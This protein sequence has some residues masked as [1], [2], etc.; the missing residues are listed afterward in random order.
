MVY[1]F[2]VDDA[3]LLRALATAGERGGML[4]VHCENRTILETLTARHLAAGE[5]APRYHASSRP[6]YVEAEATERAIALAR[7]ADAPLYVVHLSS[8]AALDGGAPRSRGRAAGVR[9]DV[10][11]LPD[12]RRV[13]LRRAAR[14]GGQGTSSRRRSVRR[15]TRT[16][17]GMAWPTAPCRWSPPTTCRTGSAVEKQSWR[18]SFDRI[19]NGGPGIET[20]L[21]MVY[22]GGVAARPDPGRAAWST[23][24]RRRRRGCS[25]CGRRGRSRSAATR[26]SCCST[27]RRR[28]TSP[29]RSDLHHTSDYT[30]Y[31]GREVRGGRALDASAAR[32]CPRRRFVGPRLRPLRC[33]SRCLATPGPVV[34]WTGRRPGP[35]FRGAGSRVEASRLDPTALEDPSGGRWPRSGRRAARSRRRCRRSPGR[36]GSCR[37]SSDGGSGAASSRARCPAP[38]R[39]SRSR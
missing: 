38:P 20:L 36:T 7:A 25:G 12:A 2:G 14:G 32:S 8:A 15:R 10:P 9:R 31:E 3:T 30:P 16:R 19:S 34:A 13:A 33:G 11:A 24:C 22:D 27:R 23:C 1:D 5:T 35:G 39:A 28:R 17:S 37:R 6:P 18:E 29:R 21:A 4:E 26:T